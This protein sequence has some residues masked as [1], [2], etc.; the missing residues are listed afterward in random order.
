[1][2]YQQFPSTAFATVALAVGVATV[3]VLA[4]AGATGRYRATRVTVGVSH[5][6]AAG[7]VDVQVL[8]TVSG[9]HLGAVATLSL[10]GISWIAYLLP[11]PG[12]PFGLNDA[13]QLSTNSTVATGAA[14]ITID[15]FADT[16]S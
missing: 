15:Y 14:Q 3:N 11:E 16:V 7:S 2:T 13:V 12:W 10:A 5:L 4:A 1:M 6:L 9:L 8:G